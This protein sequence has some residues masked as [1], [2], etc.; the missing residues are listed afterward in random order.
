MP[1]NIG[2]FPRV[3]DKNVV[4]DRLKPAISL[5]KMLELNTTGTASL[6]KYITENCEWLSE[7]K[8]YDITDAKGSFQINA[9][10][11]F[12][13]ASGTSD[14]VK[15]Q[16]STVVSSVEICLNCILSNIPSQCKCNGLT[17]PCANCKLDNIFCTCLKVV[18]VSNSSDQASAQR[19]AHEELNLASPKDIHNPEY[20][21][22]GFGLLHFCKNCISSARNY[23]LTDMSG[24]FCITLLT[25]I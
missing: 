1:L 9:F 4:F 15:K 13:P 25:A 8:E 24:T 14:D 21:Q 11:V 7:V 3:D 20:I 17:E 12:G 23:R 10:T 16:L 22:F 19:K 18:H 6:K 5:E 2:T